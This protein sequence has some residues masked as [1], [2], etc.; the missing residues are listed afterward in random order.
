[1][2]ICGKVILAFTWNKK[3][4]KN[5]EM[6]GGIRELRGRRPMEGIQWDQWVG[7]A[8]S[9]WHTHTLSLFLAQ[10]S[11]PQGIP[12]RPCR[13]DHIH[14]APVSHPGLSKSRTALSETPLCKWR[15][16]LLGEGFR[17]KSSLSSSCDFSIQNK[18]FWQDHYY[19]LP[20]KAGDHVNVCECV[21]PFPNY[22]MSQHMDFTD[23]SK[24]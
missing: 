10:L 15:M 14:Q 20:W 4:M 2:P 9:A 7:R 22:L 23:T 19:A 16:V 24:K 18:I 3:E 17:G 12:H 8:A 5:R 1:M 21:C 11:I 13:A 6:E